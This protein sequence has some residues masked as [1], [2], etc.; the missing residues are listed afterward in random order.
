MYGNLVGERGREQGGAGDVA[1]LRA[2][3]VDAA[4]NR[5]PRPQRGWIRALSRR[6]SICRTPPISDKCALARPAVLRLPTGVRTASTMYACLPHR[7]LP[8]ATSYIQNTFYLTSRYR[9]SAGQLLRRDTFASVGRLQRSR[10]RNADLSYTPEQERLRH[11]AA[12]LLCRAHDAAAAGRA[13]FGRGRLRR[14]R[15]LQ[16]V[17]RQLGRD[18]W[19]AIGWPEEY[20]GQN[21]PMM[22]QLIFTDEAAVAGVPVPFLT[23]NTVGPTIMRYGTDGTAGMFPA[24]DRQGRAALLHRLLRARRGHRPGLAAH[25]RGPRGRRVRDQRPEDV[26]L[27]DP[28]RRL[29]LAGL[30]HRRRADPA[31]GPVDDPGAG[32]QRRL[33]L[34]TGAH[35]GRRGHQRDLLR[36]RAGAPRGLSASSTAAGR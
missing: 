36:R 23:L 16:G 29:R 20:G 28:V 7:R 21:R 30:P 33:L 14:R 12:R 24:E 2:N 10:G 9:R 8:S 17:V 5:R 1:G 4:E 22:D 31:Q 13:G 32:R 27:P 15:R 19:L 25:P 26:D 3:G 34:H 35:G 18:G 6:S 11:G